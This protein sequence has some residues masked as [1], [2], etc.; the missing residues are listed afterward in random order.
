MR[1]IIHKL[2]QMTII[3]AE[4]MYMSSHEILDP[5]GCHSVV[6]SVYL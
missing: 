4:M 6:L 2:V 3:S 5:T 1:P